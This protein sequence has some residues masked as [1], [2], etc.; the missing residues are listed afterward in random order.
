MLEFE[1][2]NDSV[3]EIRLQNRPPVEE[4]PNRPKKP[5]IK[6]PE[7]PPE[8]PPPPGIPPMEE[9]PDKPEKPPVKEPPPKDPDRLP[10]Q[11]PPVKVCSCKCGPWRNESQVYAESSNLK[12]NYLL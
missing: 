7:D 6:E 10:P 12:T 5:P 8:P 4:P 9:P 2:K 3:N 11:K 1:I